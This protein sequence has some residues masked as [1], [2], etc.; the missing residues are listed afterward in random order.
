MH[1][2]AGDLPRIVGPLLDAG[3]NVVVD[4]FGRPD[5]RLGVDDPGFRYLLG[6]GGSGRLWVK[7]S[8]VYRNGA[9]GRG[10]EIARAACPLLRDAFGPGRLL[11]GSDWPHT[12]FEKTVGFSATRAQ[13]EDWFGSEADRTIILRDT[14]ESLYHF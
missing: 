7:I 14:P 12:Q 8:A 13:L 11:W 5:P 9:T 3:V 2:E 10:E 1:R 4:H 6:A